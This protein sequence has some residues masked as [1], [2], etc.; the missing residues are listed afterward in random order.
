[1]GDSGPWGPR[2]SI[3]RWRDG[4]AGA[5]GAR[6]ARTGGL[7]DALGHG[8]ESLAL[9]LLAGGLAG[10]A[11]GFGLLAGLALGRLLEGLALLHLAEDALALHLLLEDAE[12]LIDVVVT[13]ENLQV[14]SNPCVAR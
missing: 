4:R 11:H 7:Q 2:E 10:A 3:R 6:G 13:N 12:S 9:S 5:A 8:Q 1:V 14:M